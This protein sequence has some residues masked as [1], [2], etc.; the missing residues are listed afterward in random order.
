MASGYKRLKV[1]NAAFSLALDVYEITLQFPKFETHG[2]AS[3]LRQSSKS[4]AANIAEGHG[5]RK[6]GKDF[7]R[8]LINAIGSTDETKVH[9]EFALAHGYLKQETYGALIERYDL[10]GKQLSAMVASI[11]KGSFR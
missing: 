10:L 7:A 4:V 5:R 11:D 6:Y 9:L 2:L 3:Q 8:F 1:Y